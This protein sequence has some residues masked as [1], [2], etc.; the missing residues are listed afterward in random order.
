VMLKSCEPAVVR[1]RKAETR[2]PDIV[3]VTVNA[4]GWA[5]PVEFTVTSPV[6]HGTDV[7]AC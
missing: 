6:C 4:F 3:M 1:L 7:V 5:T 2:R